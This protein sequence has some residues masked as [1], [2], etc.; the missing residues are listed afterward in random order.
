MA[1]RFD[2][3]EPEPLLPD[4][5]RGWSAGISFA[6]DVVA[7]GIVT[8]D[9]YLAIVAEPGLGSSDRPHGRDPDGRGKG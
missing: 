2:G 7:L 9:E 4:I 6:G 3:G 8:E 1:A 5:P